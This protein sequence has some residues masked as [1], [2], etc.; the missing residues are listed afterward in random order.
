[1]RYAYISI[2]F[3]LLCLSSS[4]IFAQTSSNISDAKSAMQEEDFLGA[5]ALYQACIKQDS[6]EISCLQGGG[7]AAYKA[8][9]FRV[10]KELLLKLEQVDTSNTTAHRQLASIYELEENI[11]KAI[12]YCNKIIAGDSTNSTYLRKLGQL[13]LKSEFRTESFKYFSHAY[14][15]N[16]DDYYT[17]KGLI[18]IFMG[19][20]QYEEADSIL[21]I[22]LEKDTN[23]IQLILLSARSKYIQK[24]HS[25]TVEYMEKIRGKLDLNSYY[26]TM[27]GFSYLQIDSLDKAI[28]HLSKSLIEKGDK[29]H[30]SYYL[31]NAYEKK[32]D[33]ENALKYYQDAIKAGT[34]NDL[35]LYHRNMAKIYNDDDKMKKAIYHYEKTYE[36]RK[37]PLM[38]FFL[39]RCSDR[40]Y[41]DKSIAVR[42]Y[43]KYE[44][45]NHNNQEYKEYAN[46]RRIYLMEQIHLSK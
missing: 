33:M 46:Q 25:T 19:N 8:G 17:I 21:T 44:K 1:M 22:A 15:I 20:K 29:E 30:A 37:D 31:A 38:L 6:L 32:G 35:G 26:N 4:Q 27:L 36:Y 24:D 13:Y 2:M 23:N 11:P 39:A 43:K 28:H 45:S 3:S 12:K 9:N 7:I 16:P 18:E 14:R 10:A 5:L 41:K 42:Y 34:S 40:Y